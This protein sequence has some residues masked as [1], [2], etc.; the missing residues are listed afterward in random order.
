VADILVVDD[1][2]SVAAAFERFL[3]H[4]G[5]RPFVASNAASALRLIG[6]HRPDV[7]FMDVRMPGVDGLQALQEFRK[8]FP[9]LYVVIMTA[10]GT[11]QTSIDAIRAG[12]FEYVTKPLDLGGLRGLIA[13]AL[14]AQAGGRAWAAAEGQPPVALVG[15]SPSMRDV[16][17]LIGRLATNDVPALVVG[18]H[19]TGKALVVATIHHNSTRR[20]GPLV[21][22][23]AALASDES[24][25]ANLVAAQGGTLH[26]ASVH[27]L[28]KRLQPTLARAIDDALVPGAVRP[29]ASVRVLATTEY[30]LA[31]AVDEGVFGRQLYEALSVI[32]LHLQ[33]LRERRQD[34]PLLIDHFIRRFNDV[35][36]R[37]IRGIDAAAR[38]RLVEFGWPGNVAELEMTVKRACIVAKGDLITNADLGE[39]LGHGRAVGRQHSET[40]LARVSRTALHERLVDASSDA[41]ISVFHDIVAVVEAALVNEALVITNGNQVKAAELLGVNRTTLRKKAEM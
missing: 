31:A 8:Q 35:L 37:S 26:V 13:H 38:G 10:H 18:E 11:S 25:A 6:E 20:D 3:R 15:D 28:P 30:D 27:A 41:S 7:V 1:D 34:I 32:T 33:P 9:D 19:G 16:Y 2:Q 17:K 36:G 5:H 12:A 29:P 14:S 21:T 40:A 23:D 4:E 24:L 39:T 22:V